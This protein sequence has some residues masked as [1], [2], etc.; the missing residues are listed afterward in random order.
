VRDW[1]SYFDFDR[2]TPLLVDEWNYDTSAN[3]LPERQEKSY[4][5]ASFVPS[6]IKNMY[7]AGIDYQ[8]YFC[9]EDFQN[10]KEGVVR[11]VGIFSFDAE[12]SEYRGA[13]KATYNVF[14]MLINLGNNMFTTSLKPNDEFVDVVATKTQDRI[15]ILIYNYIDPEIAMSY[16]SRNIAALNG[17]ERKALLNLIT[18]SKLEKIMSRQ[19]DI[20]KMRPSKKLKTLLAKAQELND[21]AIKFKSNARNLNMKIKNIKGNYLYQRYIVDSTCTKN[22]G[23]RPIEEQEL[24][25]SDSHQEILTLNP[26][27]VQ[28][29]ILTKKPS[30]TESA[31]GQTAEQE[32]PRK[33]ENRESTGK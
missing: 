17:A 15:V 16:L 10:N 26:Y 5:S 7:E 30:E 23:F 11:N 12:A 24:N 31:S 9:L 2:N 22:C 14:K 6:R 28:M 32:E 20:V 8:L 1:L 33:I 18:S 25:L 13:S 19:L 3:V 4:I 27:S 21:K 29:I